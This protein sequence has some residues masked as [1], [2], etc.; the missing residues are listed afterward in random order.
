[1]DV[2]LYV[3]MYLYLSVYKRRNDV[4]FYILY[5]SYTFV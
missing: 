3:C 4:H 1:M 2:C 5:I